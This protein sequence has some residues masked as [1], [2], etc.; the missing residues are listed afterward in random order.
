LKQEIIVSAKTV[1]AAVKEG[2]EKL[3]VKVEEVT[4]EV[5]TEPKKG[6]FGFGEVKA[7]VKVVYEKSPEKLAIEFLKT[8]IKDM[9]LNAEITVTNGKGN[10]KN[11]AIKGSDAGVLIGHHG[12]TLDA[13]QYLV[14]LVAN[15]KEDENEDRNYTKISLDIENYRE[16]RQETLETLARRMSE[17]VLKYKKSI[18]LEPMSPYERRIIHSAVQNI[19]GVS[20]N[21]IGNDNNRRV[22]IFLEK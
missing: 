13:L 12:D 3:G 9:E 17:K 14:N 8:L 18:T 19:Q 4:Y 16:K 22:V 6:F 15:K 1:D 21:S 11:I 7:E 10:E 2:A 20:T 5:I